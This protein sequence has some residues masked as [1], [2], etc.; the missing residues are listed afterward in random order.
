MYLL[1]SCVIAFSMYSKIPMPKVEWSDKNLKYFLCF[2]PFVGV[3][4]GGVQILLGNILLKGGF[5]SLFF[6]A[7]MTLLPLLV[8]GGIHMDG[9][10]DT[11]DALSSFGD[12]EKK[13]AILKDP[14]A[15]AF[16]ILW[17][18]IYLVWSLALWSQVR[19][20]MLPVIVCGYIVSRSLSGFSVVLFQ[21][22]RDSGLAKNFQDKAQKKVVAIIMLVW[23]FG[24]STVMFIWE[25]L[26]GAVQ[27]GMAGVLFLYH[28]YICKKHFGGITGDLA[29][30]FLQLCE[31]AMLTGTVLAGGTLWS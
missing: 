18:G 12:K 14:H 21:A 25:P 17:F 3:F 16:A 1:K 15:G 10:M 28:R 6:S 23:L 7:V 8:T 27:L 26:L 20:F 31:L 22:A 29:G 9:F 19:G 2:F 4:L 24:A 13:L 5:G 30:Y 11:V